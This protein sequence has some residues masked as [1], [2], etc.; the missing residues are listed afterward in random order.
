MIQTAYGNFDGDLWER[1]CK[2]CFNR[3][4]ESEKYFDIVASPGDYGLEGFTKTGKAFQC[5][6][7]DQAYSANE[8]YKNQRK[9]ITTDLAKLK[10]Y[11]PELKARLGDTTIITWYFV[12]PEYRKNDILAHCVNKTKE[13]KGW[14]LSI[15]NKTDFDVVPVDIDFLHPYLKVALDGTGTKLLLPADNLEEADIVKYEE[16]S[17]T[18][19]ANAKEKHGKRLHRVSGTTDTV[20]GLTHRTIKN[21][22]DG[23]NILEKFREIV[24]EDYER[25]IRIMEQQ[26]GD[27]KDLS[28]SPSSDHNQRYI[29]VKKDIDGK[30]RQSFPNLD[31]PTI[32]DLSNYV[33]AEWILRCPLDFIDNDED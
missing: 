20:D 2:I 30:V 27:V 13:V 26:T 6:C 23:S 16:D 28:L 24:P 21:F 19:V 29:D 18:L 31:D 4:Y 14:N 5:Y 9:K 33:I 7:P 3:K 15:I 32:K 10:L 12:T 22:L 25:F 1:V 17:G 8:L 11:E